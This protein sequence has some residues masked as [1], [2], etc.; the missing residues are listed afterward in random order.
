MSLTRTFVRQLPRLS[1]A[2]RSFSVMPRRA[3]EGDTG[4]PRG[5]GAAQSDAFTKREQA[6][7]DY[8]VKEQEKQKLQELRKR[9][10]D[11][12]ADIAKD[13]EEAEKIAK[14]AS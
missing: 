3:A 4:A 14:K 13:R 2:A 8:Y 5:G 10:A 11:K 9:I 12:E 1:T 6:N 7:E